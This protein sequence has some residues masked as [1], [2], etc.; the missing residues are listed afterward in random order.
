MTRASTCTA[1]NRMRAVIYLAAHEL[2]ARWQGWAVLVLLVAVAGGAVLTAAAGALRTDTAYPRFL[3][4]S[5]ASDVLVAPD[6]WGP[7][8]YFDALARLPGVAAVAPLAGMNLEPLGHGLAAR[9][10]ATAAPVDGRFGRL[11]EVPKVLA[12]RLPAAGRAGEIAV[13]QRGA[14]MLGL[15]VGSVLS[16]R[17]VPNSP[18]PGAGTA[19]PRLLRERV[20]GIVVTR[21]SVLPVTEMDKVPVIMASLALF[22]RLGVQYAGFGGAY[23]KLRPGASAEEFGRQAQSLTR[24]FPSTGGHVFTADEG[25]QAAAV[26]R[27]I[28]P[29]AVALAVFALALAVTALLI[30]G[31]AATRLLATGLLT[32]PALTALGM[33]RGQLTAAGL[34]EVGAAAAI[35]A[36]VAAGAA[37]AASPLM[38]I[39]AARLAEPDPGVSANPAVLAAGAAAI[40]VLLLAWAAWPA[41]RL[42]AAGARVNGTAA[43]PGPR[44][45]PVAWLAGAGLPVTV[46]AGVRLALEPGRG[47]TA[48]P[49]RSALAGTV[50]SVLAVTAAVTFGANLL[51]LVNSPRL[52]GQRWDAAVD[53]QFGGITPAFAGQRLGHTP[54]IT[55]WTFGHHGIVGIGGHVIP[56]IGLAAGKGPLL[57]PTLLQGRPPRTSDEI[58]LGTAT[59]RQ[60]GRHV[61]QTVT[62]TVGGRTLRERI[63]GRVVFPNFGQGSFTPTD[64]GQ[65]AQT[66]AAVLKPPPSAVPSFDFVLL[67]F[68]PG[69]RRVADIAS[70]EQSMTGFCQAVPQS[71]CVVTSQRPNGVTNYA[72]IDRTPTVLAAILAVVGTAV[73]GQFIVVSG[74]RRRRDFAILKALGLRR[75]QVRSITAWQVSTL[76]GIALLAGLPLGIVVGRWSW[77]LFGHGLGIPAEVVTPVRPVLIMVPAVIVIA[78]AVALWPGQAT[79]RLRPANVLRAE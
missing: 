51:H 71:T 1:G 66:T 58:A 3:K 64:L 61:G 30:V 9:A 37:V 70:F 29:E 11:V 34:T 40:I 44:L 67:R 46:R 6:V 63:V 2:R 78:N 23:V 74:R 49:V 50:L 36:V 12:G 17:A 16:M 62:M 68:T 10:T 8:G 22:Q 60:I 14:A 69:P 41:W 57:S 73:L 4:A 19:G 25:A 15:R 21:G 39:G 77:A 32:N 43:A 47:R 54:G 76:T 28:R 79:A 35:G 42:A 20:V 18:S 75:R 48:V 52:Y 55:G 27:A 45:R 31:Q 59:L 7:R 13:D 38:P 24:Q 72:S 65:G 5:K 56:A 26:Q 33:T 53:L